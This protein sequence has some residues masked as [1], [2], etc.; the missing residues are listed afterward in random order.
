MCIRDR[1]LDEPDSLRW[2][3]AGILAHEWPPLQKDIPARAARLAKSTIERLASEGKEEQARYFQQVIDT[4]LIRDLDLKLT[5]NGDADIDLIIE[6]PPGTICSIASPRT[7]SGGILVDDNQSGVF[8]TNKGFRMERYIVTNAFPGTY[9]VL[10]SRATGKV[11]AGFITAEVTIHKGTSFQETMKRQLPLTGDEILFTIEL[12]TG[13][14]R[15][16]VAELSLIHI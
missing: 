7:H 13:R 15:Q 8:E 4:S 3:C 9:K 6:E 14:R 5:W 12:P 16:P 10:V 1:D 11:T 2:T